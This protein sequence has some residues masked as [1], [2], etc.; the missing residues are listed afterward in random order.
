MQVQHTSY[1]QE[2]SLAAER[3]S[4]L[5]PVPEMG[6]RH[7]HVYELLAMYRDMMVVTLAPRQ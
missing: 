5:S 7:M 6:S 2:S 3:K 4:C 1:Y